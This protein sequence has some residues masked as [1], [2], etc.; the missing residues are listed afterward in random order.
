MNV[1]DTWLYL[2]LREVAKDTLFSFDDKP[3]LIFVDGDKMYNAHKDYYELVKTNF[4]IWQ[5]YD[6]RIFAYRF[7]LSDEG[8]E[9]YEFLQE[10]AKVQYHDYIAEVKKEKRQ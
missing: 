9:H 2:M 6:D 8:W 7:I 3:T 1:P 10:Q 4:V 5:P